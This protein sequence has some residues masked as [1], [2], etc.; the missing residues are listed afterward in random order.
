LNY[1]K[2]YHSLLSCIGVVIKATLDDVC[3]MPDPAPTFMLIML[4]ILQEIIET[5]NGESGLL[6]G[7]QGFRKINVEAE[8]LRKELNE[9]IR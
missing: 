4:K 1:Q 5:K 8:K 6:T 3:V 2:K 9:A 7:A